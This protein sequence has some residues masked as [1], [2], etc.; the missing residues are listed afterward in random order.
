MKQLILTCQAG[1]NTRLGPK[2]GA[3]R[4]QFT[5]ENDSS[6]RD[7][8]RVIEFKRLLGI[9]VIGTGVELH[10]GYGHGADI[11]FADGVPSPEVG[12]AVAEQ[13]RR[14]VRRFEEEDGW[15]KTYWIGEWPQSDVEQP[16]PQNR[17]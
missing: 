8:R 7:H 4:Y 9:N 2:P 12:L 11:T 16:V 15:I 10:N 6:T 5:F 13:C 3:Y 1:S 17:L 14:A